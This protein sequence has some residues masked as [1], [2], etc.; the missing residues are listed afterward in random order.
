MC[1]QALRNGSSAAAC[2][3]TPIE[4]RTFCPSVVTENPATRAMP[5]VGG[6]RVVSMCTVVDLPAPL[7]PEEPVHLAR[8]D[9]QA[10]SVD[11]AVA[12]ELLDQA[13]GL[14]RVGR[15]TA[16]AGAA[17]AAL[18][19]GSTTV[20]SGSWTSITV[21]PSPT[22][23]PV[24]SATVS[25]RRSPLTDVPLVEPRSCTVSPSP[26]GEKLACRREISGS[27]SRTT[28]ATPASRPITTWVGTGT[29]V[30]AR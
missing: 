17:V 26:A 21:A 28:S 14:D 5:S 27:S 24:V 16:V 18:A 11:G 12:V 8:L 23:S 1:S 30:P 6:S 20:S 3:A 15:Q 25:V 10:D 7:G 19:A 22:R 13:L 29:S 2:S 9:P 4:A